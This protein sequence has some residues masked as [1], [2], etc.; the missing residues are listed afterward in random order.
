MLKKMSLSIRIA[1]IVS[2]LVA[3]ILTIVILIIN[4]RLSF[5]IEKLISDQNFQIVSARSSEIDKLIDSYFW[6][7]NMLS[8][9][10]TVRFSDE[11]KAENY[12]SI[13]KNK[14]HAEISNVIIAWSD[15][16][17]LTPSGDYVNISD[18]S[19][20]KT[21][22]NE[23][24][25]FVISEA[26]IS[27]GTGKPAI[28]LAKAIKDSEN[29]TKAILIFELQL[30]KLS[31]IISG[32]Q[33]GKYG[34][35]WIVDEK[36]LVIAH[37]NKDII[38]KLNITEAD[39]S[40]YKGLSYFSKSLLSNKNGFGR[41]KDKKGIEM[42]T[43]YSIINNT[44]GWK[45]GISI[46]SSE[47]HET[48]QGI[49]IILLIILF[50][51][52]LTSIFVSILISRWITKPI[53][54][55]SDS[56]N[57]LAVG[58]ADL[59]KTLA[60]NRDDE[61]GK[62]VANFNLFMQKLREIVIN[63]KKSQGTF[64]DI[65]NELHNSVE[66]NSKSIMEIVDG[67]EGIQSR[68]VEQTNSIVESSSAVT[69]ISKNI[70]SLNLLISNQIASISEASSSIEEMVGNISSVTSSIEMITKEFTAISSTSEKGK[71]V[72]KKMK[73]HI[74]QIEAQSKTLLETNNT[75][76]N[77][78]TQT[79]LLAMNAAIESAHAGEA[80]KGFS[81]VA[82]EIRL[83]AETSS[84]QSKIISSELKNVQNAIKLVVETSNESEQ[85]FEFLVSQITHTNI[86]VTEVMQAMI[87]QKNGSSQILIAL[88]D[89]NDI[90][91]QVKSGY[92]EISNGNKTILNEIISLREKSEENKSSIDDISNRSNDINKNI[93]LLKGLTDKVRETMSDIGNSI[94]RFKT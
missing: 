10:D 30:E 88:K 15:G 28:M 7:I 53:K 2:F 87:E 34:Y 29:T 51:S 23:N 6:E 4:F 44:P 25:D 56:F 62:L 19:Y 74:E 47:V 18:R 58:D 84:E 20:F 9:N 60:I 76:S 14:I 36:G 75:V 38:M 82:E 77:I 93:S 70:D 49:L 61:I 63:L 67:I 45:L 71:L 86:L 32:I 41:W 31:E 92:L 43:Y 64:E 39:K 57:D 90:T 89:M 40:G 42:T 80:G 33:I 94:I 35:G 78:A 69:Q 16:R 73:E 81:V 85:S 72:Q 55:T 11:K 37:K 8:L 65:A 79:N 91:S 54:S 66:E 3:L 21:I 1:V 22:F 27:K 17:T 5:V 50:V 13:I 12:I 52:T 83:L 24:K 48:R 46:P 26:I 59:T 68:I